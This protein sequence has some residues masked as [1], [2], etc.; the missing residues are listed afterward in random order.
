MALTDKAKELLEKKL[1]SREERQ[2]LEPKSVRSETDE[3]DEENLRIV[4]GW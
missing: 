1:A 4:S 3:K 2:A